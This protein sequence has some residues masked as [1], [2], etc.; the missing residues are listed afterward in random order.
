MIKTE[1][2]QRPKQR[3]RLAF[4]LASQPPGPEDR[5]EGL[6]MGASF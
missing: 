5:D 3:Q 2:A 6:F 4:F 1:R